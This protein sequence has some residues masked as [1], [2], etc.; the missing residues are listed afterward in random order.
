VE[1][2]IFLSAASASQVVPLLFFAFIW[3]DHQHGCPLNDFQTQHYF[4]TCCPLILSAGGEFPC[5]R[6]VSSMKTEWHYRLLFCGT[7]LP[8][9]LLLHINL[10]PK[11]HLKDCCA[12]CCMLALLQVLPFTKK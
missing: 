11:K 1:L 8:V 4:L 5:K 7:K 12:I 10:S 3:C 9:S 6:H 2:V